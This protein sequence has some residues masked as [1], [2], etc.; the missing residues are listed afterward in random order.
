MKQQ[1][2]TLTQSGQAATEYIVVTL[3]I[4][5]GLVALNQGDNVIAELLDSVKLFFRAYS[6]TISIP[7]QCRSGC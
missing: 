5:I 2:K 1:K 7:A 6:Y 3:F 4:A